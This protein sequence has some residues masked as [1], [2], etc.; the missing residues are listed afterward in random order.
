MRI[1]LR[2]P[3]HH[4]KEKDICPSI[5]KSS[6]VN[7][8]KINFDPKELSYLGVG[9][10]LYFF[11]LKI[12]TFYV[13]VLAVIKSYSLYLYSTSDRCSSEAG[14]D[15]NI[16][17]LISVANYVWSF[18]ELQFEKIL[19]SCFMIML[20]ATNFWFVKKAKDYDKALDVI[21]DSPSDYSLMVKLFLK[22]LN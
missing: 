11:L 2:Q 12:L 18:G 17:I 20:L 7:P 15:S 1:G 4:A 19:Q 16:F 6:I 14:C 8:H 9:Y 21:E 3:L 22:I 5:V 10:P 13:L